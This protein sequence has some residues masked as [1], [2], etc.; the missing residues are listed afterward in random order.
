MTSAT[1]PRRT[2]GVER[3][4][5][6]STTRA[7]V[8]SSDAPDRA[9]RRGG[10]VIHSARAPRLNWHMYISQQ[11]RFAQVPWRRRRRRGRLR[12]PRVPHRRARRDRAPALVPR[13][14]PDRVAPRESSVPRP[15]A[16][17]FA[18]VRDA[19]A[20][21]LPLG[22]ARARAHRRPRRTPAR[23]PTP[24]V[25][26]RV[27]GGVVPVPSAT[28]VR[29]VG[30]RFLRTIFR[31]DCSGP[32]RPRA[33]EPALPRWSRSRYES[34]ER[35]ELLGVH[36]ASSFV[37]AANPRPP[38]SVLE[39]RAWIADDPRQT[40]PVFTDER[41]SRFLS[42]LPRSASSSSREEPV[43]VGKRPPGG[44]GRRD[45]GRPPTSSSASSSSSYGRPPPPPPP[46]LS[47]PGG[48]APPP[49]PF[50]GCPCATPAVLP[51]PALMH[52]VLVLVPV[53]QPPYVAHRGR[54]SRCR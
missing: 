47:P 28:L 4:H 39:V 48:A 45:H 6:S 44:R 21:G 42:P 30:G 11:R 50:A 2:S 34:R 1:L 18:V 54:A 37:R 13:E 38:A 15:D 23:P 32:S 17:A 22:R 20:F 52:P 36:R 27:R 10:G 25:R 41:Q 31:T 43:P 26:R 7:R 49:A 33:V 19:R 14:R 5:A 12:S 46:P 53:R 3:K 40:Q 51:V 24:R 16:A 29:G 8:G 35:R 9:W